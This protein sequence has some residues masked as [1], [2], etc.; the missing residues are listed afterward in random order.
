MCIPDVFGVF[1]RM[2]LKKGASTFYIEEVAKRQFTMLFTD[3]SVAT[4]G[5]SSP[6]LKLTLPA[7]TKSAWGPRTQTSRVVEDRPISNT[8]LPL[9]GKSLP[10]AHQNCLSP[11]NYNLPMTLMPAI[12]HYPWRIALFAG[13]NCTYCRRICNAPGITV[14]CASKNNYR[15]KKLK[16][17]TSDI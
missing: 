16:F 13:D 8:M 7:T 6:T 10:P 15:S 17:Y 12:M 14:L 1:L 4:R 5:V 9:V 3:Q 2:H 11:A